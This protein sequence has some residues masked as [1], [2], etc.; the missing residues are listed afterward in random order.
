MDP[1]SNLVF[2]ELQRWTTSILQDPYVKLLPGEDELEKAARSVVQTLPQQ[3]IG[4]E[5]TA[6][7]LKEDIAPS[8]NASSLSPNYYGFVTGGI[9][10]AARIAENIVSLFDQNVCVHLPK[11][12]IATMVEDRALSLLL[13]L[14]DL[15]PTKWPARVLTTGA[16]ASNVV[17]LA[18]GREFLISSK[19]AQVG[20]Q[21]QEGEGLLPSCLKAGIED[22]QILTTMPHSSLGK[23]ANIVGL[24]SASMVDV[25]TDNH[26]LHFDLD[27]L[28]RYLESKTA[29]IVALSSGEVNT[30]QFVTSSLEEFKCIRKLCDKYGAWLHCDGGKLEFLR[31]NPPKRRASKN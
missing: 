15:E 9:T 13:Q 1:A 4:L 8:L 31:F 11:E 10:P 27:K 2:Q 19:L 12:S 16:T 6:E 28:E 21:R 14:F 23:A 18:C 5:K 26:H 29:S 24:G 25:S 20:S 30:G 7:H 22:F 17:G 3:G